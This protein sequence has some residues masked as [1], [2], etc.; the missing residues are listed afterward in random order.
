MIVPK[1]SQ[2]VNKQLGTQNYHLFQHAINPSLCSPHDLTDDRRDRYCQV[3]PAFRFTLCGDALCRTL[4]FG[5]FIAESRRISWHGTRELLKK[6]ILKFLIFDRENFSRQDARRAT[7]RMCGYLFDLHFF[8]HFSDNRL[9]QTLP[10]V[11]S[12]NLEGSCAPIVHLRQKNHAQT[13][14]L[15]VIFVKIWLPD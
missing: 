14:V 2:V 5:L 15:S 3:N 6:S 8:G 7:N 4:L 13:V 11:L 9:F 1:S 10:R 12:T